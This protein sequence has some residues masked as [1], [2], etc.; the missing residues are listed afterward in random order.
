MRK[1]SRKFDSF[2]VDIYRVFMIYFHANAIKRFMIIINGGKTNEHY[3]KSGTE[4]TFSA[5]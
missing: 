3:F 1:K 5:R 4:D 2:F